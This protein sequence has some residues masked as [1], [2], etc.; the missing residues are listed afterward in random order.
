MVC[1]DDLLTL[2]GIAI[3]FFFL[4][5][6]VMLLIFMNTGKRK[7][8][9]AKKQARMVLSL[10][11]ANLAGMAAWLVLSIIRGLDSLQ[12]LG[13]ILV[14]SIVIEALVLYALNRKFL[15]LK[16][17]LLLSLVLNIISLALFLTFLI[18]LITCVYTSELA[19]LP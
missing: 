16:T 6:V 12:Q 13:V 8:K 4:V 19:L 1:I 2:I 10:L 9:C 15:G 7:E 5:E 14:G 18:P 17:A 3:V 11:A